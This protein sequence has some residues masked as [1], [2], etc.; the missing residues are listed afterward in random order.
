MPA[1]WAPASVGHSVEHQRF[2]H[3]LLAQRLA[4]ARRAREAL[5]VD[6]GERARVLGRLD[7]ELRVRLLGLGVGDLGEPV[8]MA[9]ARVAVVGRRRAGD[10]DAQERP[11]VALEDRALALEQQRRGERRRA[12]EHLLAGLDVEAVA[13]E[14]VG[15]AGGVEAHRGEARAQPSAS[16]ASGSARV[17]RQQLRRAP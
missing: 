4:R 3:R 6:A 16:A 7:G 8:E 10:L 5:G 13:G 1:C 12:H 17:G 15:E 2:L 14:E 9:V 11:R